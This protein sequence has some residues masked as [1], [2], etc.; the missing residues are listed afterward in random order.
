MKNE[1]VLSE[2]TEIMEE[3]AKYVPSKETQQEVVIEEGS[4]PEKATTSHVHHILFGG[5]QLTV[6]RIRGVTRQRQTSETAQG[7]MEGLIP[8]VEDWHAKLCLMSV[9]ECMIAP[10]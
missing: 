9:S 3:L 7:R 4:P 5:D 8:V 6:A 1:N 10:L 2:M